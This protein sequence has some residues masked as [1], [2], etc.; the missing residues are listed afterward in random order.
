MSWKEYSDDFNLDMS[1]DI[2][3]DLEMMAE[4]D[5]EGEKKV[6]KKASPLSE[7]N[8]FI[9]GVGDSIV[10]TLEETQDEELRL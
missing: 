4:I 7:L 5:A 2:S 9:D 10:K 6:E 3:D 8:D 1:E